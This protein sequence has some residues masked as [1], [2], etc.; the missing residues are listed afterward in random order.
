MHED[1]VSL[2]EILNWDA[3]AYNNKVAVPTDPIGAI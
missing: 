1:S 3:F 2:L